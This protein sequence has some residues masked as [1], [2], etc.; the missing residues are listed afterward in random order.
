[1]RQA[2]PAPTTA[3]SA[4]LLRR[5]TRSRRHLLEQQLERVAL[6]GGCVI[7]QLVRIPC[8]RELH[9]L[10]AWARH[11]TQVLDDVW[12]TTVEHRLVRDE[13]VRVINPWAPVARPER[14]LLLVEEHWEACT[15]CTLRSGEG[16][17]LEDT[18]E[19]SR[20]V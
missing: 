20:R 12:N 18:A 11:G 4:A 19:S 10:D 13:D 17:A 1:M 5:N 8:D 9:V 6:H 14:S 15:E 16:S 2:L 3:S 7:D